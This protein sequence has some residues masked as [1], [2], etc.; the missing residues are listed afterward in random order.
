MYYSISLSYVTLVSH[1]V[2]LCFTHF[3]CCCSCYSP[4]GTCVLEYSKSHLV[5]DFIFLLKTFSMAVLK[6]LH[7][8][9]IEFTGSPNIELA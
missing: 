8:V 2:Y 1:H 6:D 9:Y 3:V 7:R 4:V 5:T